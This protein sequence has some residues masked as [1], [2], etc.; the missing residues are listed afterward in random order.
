[1][2]IVSL[3]AVL[4]PATTQA[5]A[6][7]AL[8]ERKDLTPESFIRSFADFTFELGDCVQDP[9]AFLQRR[10]GDCDDF[11]SL[12]AAI[13]KDRG[14][15]TKVVVVMMNGATHVVCYVKEAHGFLDFN[16][17]ADA[18]PIV[19]SDGSLEDIAEKVSDYFR[20]HWHMASEIRYE[21]RAPIFITS[22]F[23]LA[24]PKKPVAD[25]K[26]SIPT[27]TASATPVVATP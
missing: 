26:P 11:A 5:S 16:H 24:A 19:E 23:P 13:L 4:L 20:A 17:R 27:I 18:Y 25:T 21:K 12:A 8:T 14:Y 1:M 7:T 9:E 15:S 10:R 22:T 6:L 2:L 3:I